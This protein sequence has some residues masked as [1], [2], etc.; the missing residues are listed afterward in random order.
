MPPTKDTK[1]GF[2][3]SSKPYRVDVESRLRSA[4]NLDDKQLELALR[5]IRAGS[6]FHDPG[7]QKP[8]DGGLFQ[9]FKLNPQILKAILALFAGPYKVNFQNGLNFTV[10]FVWAYE[11]WSGL[12]LI[13]ETPYTAPGGTAPISYPNCIEMRQYAFSVW[14]ESDNELFVSPTLTVQQINQIEIQQGTW[15]LCEDTI[16]VY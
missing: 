13:E 9:L 12:I 14:D 2:K 10:Q 3:S 7:V 8:L 11:L 15:K 6:I 1:V 5:L 16:E 4:G